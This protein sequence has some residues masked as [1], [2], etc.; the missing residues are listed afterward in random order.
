MIYKKPIRILVFFI[1]V[2][3]LS[4]CTKEKAEAIKIA[5]ENFRIDAVLAIDKINELFDQNISVAKFSEKKIEIIISDLENLG[6]SDTAIN[7]E[8]LDEWFKEEH[9]AVVSSAMHKDEFNKIKKRFTT[10]E[11]MFTNLEKGNYFAKDAVKKAEK[12]AINLSLDLIHYSKILKDTPFKNMSERVL[13][14]ERIEEARLEE[15]EK[16]QKVLREN[17][18][19]DII[20][21]GIRE[22]K[23]KEEAI[24][25]CLLAADRGKIVAELIKDYDTLNVEDILNI[26]KT[27]LNYGIDITGNKNINDLLTKFEGVES[28]IRNDA[29]WKV[30]IDQQIN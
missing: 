4:G 15:N 23:L 17:V 13:I 25:Q 30:I 20:A 10:F 26:V 11:A 8:I 29:Y 27:S 16:F 19:R 3:I 12:Y 18:A 6:S 7:S 2:L 28:E 22:T 24:R 14:I 21:L 5:A 9:I 1:T